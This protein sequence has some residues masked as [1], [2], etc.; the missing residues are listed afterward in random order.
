MRRRISSDLHDDIGSTLNSVKVYASLALS[1]PGN[2]KHL[3]QVKNNTQ[4]AISGLR[5]VIWVLDDKQD[6]VEQLTA[7]IVH[8][9][10]PLCEANGI[11]FRSTIDPDL[12]GVKLDKQEKR[13][14]FLILKES[15][16]NSTKYAGCSVIE[17]IVQRESQ[18]L[19]FIVKD[20]GKGFDTVNPNNGNGLKNIQSRAKQSG[21]K[22]LIQSDRGAGTTIT[23]SK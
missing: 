12:Y 6:T 4:E 21:Y 7:R 5:D 15:I 10:R 1:Q 17:L 14:V 16:N 20:N 8:F 22:A 13:N 19:Q 2:D 3:L 11:D 18:R 9:F 23:L